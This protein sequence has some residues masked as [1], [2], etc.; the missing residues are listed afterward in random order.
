MVGNLN[1]LSIT[2]LYESPE[3][4]RWVMDNGIGITDLEC[5]NRIINDGYTSLR[6][7]IRQHTNDVEGF[8][9]Y[10]SNLN[11]TF[12]SAREAA[13]RVYYSPVVISR[14]AGVVHY[15]D[16]CVHSLHTIPDLSF[17][18][19]DTVGQSA[20]QGDILDENGRG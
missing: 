11:K 18:D 7:I 1:P 12:A 10:L 2:E 15:Y 13:M 5:R 3:A 6:T 14:F 4:L 16:Q 9:S 20:G 19:V 8:K 17:L